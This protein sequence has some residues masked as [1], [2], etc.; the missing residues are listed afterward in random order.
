VKIGF[1][2]LLTQFFTHYK[3][4][5]VFRKIQL[6]F[7]GTSIILT[8]FQLSGGKN[9]NQTFRRFYGGG[10]GAGAFGGGLREKGFGRERIFAQ[11]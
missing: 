1:S 8:F 6:I 10:R 9:E 4:K 3:V 5:R 2:P 7:T 11:L